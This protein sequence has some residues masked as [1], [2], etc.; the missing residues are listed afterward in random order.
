MRILLLADNILSGRE[1][2]ID[3]VLAR[4]RED[5]SD[6]TKVT[7]AYQYEAFGGIEWI[8][9]NKRALGID[10]GTI[11][12]L[13]EEVRKASGDIF[14]HVI[15][16]IHPVNWKDGFFRIGGWNLG[17]FYSDYSVQIVKATE[18]DDWLYK[19]FAME[20]IH[21]IDEFAYKELG[22]NLDNLMG[23]DFDYDIIHGEHKDWGVKQPD[24]SYFT[25][26]DYTKV[27]AYFA[28]YIKRA[29]ELREKKHRD[30]QDKLIGIR[31][32]LNLIEQIISLYRTIF[33]ALKKH[34]SAVYESELQGNPRERIKGRH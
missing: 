5:Y 25:D 32:Q 3:D 26:Y 18:R 9:Y 30:K 31:M 27:I 11:K 19:I 23:M 29:Y 33:M 13:T 2:H 6:V 20:L 8:N 12:E 16:L 34:P 21:S 10:Y 7:W 4:I 24:G 28:A 15:L 1:E 22:I 14:D 17:R